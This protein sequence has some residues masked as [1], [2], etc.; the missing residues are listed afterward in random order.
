MA[1]QKR[2]QGRETGSSGRLGDLGGVCSRRI[3]AVCRSKMFD[4]FVNFA[5]VGA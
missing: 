5:F 2:A 4:S 3:K 1:W